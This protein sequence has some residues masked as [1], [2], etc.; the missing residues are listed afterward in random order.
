MTMM[1]IVDNMVLV[2]VI[3]IGERKIVKLDVVFVIK[4]NQ[5]NIYY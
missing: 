4:T 1:K 3:W 5:L 2:Y